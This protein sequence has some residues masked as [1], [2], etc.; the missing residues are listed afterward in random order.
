MRVGAPRF[1]LCEEPAS[2]IGA[3]L[4]ALGWRPEACAAHLG[5]LDT[6]VVS[7]A[8]VIVVVSTERELLTP[9]LHADAERVARGT[10]RVVV[11]AEASSDAAAYA[12][13]LGWH[14]FV[15]AEST[16]SALLKAIAAAAR[17]DLSFPAS[18]TSALARA[19]ARL[20]PVN[21]YPSS[22]LTPRQRQIVALLAQGA[23]DAE[24][25]SLLQISP[26]TAH[27]H[28]QNAR[29]RMRAKTRSQLVAS[30]RTD[31]LTTVW[32]T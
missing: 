25:G 19:L 4:S 32:P 1:V 29:R 8:E 17:G 3:R 6:A 21:G 10:P 11:I 16:D 13:R 27:K 15:S 20:A 30:A 2:R 22:A 5:D 26:A 7:S 14:A 12:A 23:T 24:I 18:A 9:A 28:V 31:S